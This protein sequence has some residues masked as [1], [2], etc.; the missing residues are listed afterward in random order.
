MVGVIV[1]INLRHKRKKKKLLSQ[2]I[3]DLT[4]QNK[5]AEEQHAI[6]TQ[7]IDNLSQLHDAY[8]KKI[9]ADIE[10]FC[11]LI[12][13]E[14][15]LQEHLHWRNF[16]E[17]CELSNKYFY[18]I[19]TKLQPYNLSH[20]EIRLCILVLIKANTNQMINMIPYAQSGLGKFK[21]TTSNKLG[22]TTPNLRTFILGLLG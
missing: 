17:M 18:N 6:L 5:E 22:T 12:R 15:D 2:Q 9:I 4:I 7:N 3:K 1:A 11:M 20:K 13:N 14:Q 8:H 16:A 19:I 21:Y 10:Q